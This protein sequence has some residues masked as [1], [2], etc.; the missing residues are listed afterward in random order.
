MLRSNLSGRA[1]ELI[2]LPEIHRIYGI[3]IRA[4][5]RA[6]AR[7]DFPVY[8]AGTSWPRVLRREFEEWLSSTRIDVSAESEM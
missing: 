5:R 1:P 7:G 3:G 2:T 4:L 6:A 8:M